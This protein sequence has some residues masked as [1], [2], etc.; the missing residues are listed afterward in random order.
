MKKL[1]RIFGLTI[2]WAVGGVLG[3]VLLVVL[4]FLVAKPT[5]TLRFFGQFAGERPGHMQ[6]VAGTPEKP[7]P[8]ASVGEAALSIESLQAAMDYGACMMLMGVTRGVATETVKR[9][10]REAQSAAAVRWPGTKPKKRS[11]SPTPKKKARANR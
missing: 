10:A 5:E 11:D 2:A 3:L 1:L 4:G 8:K 6:L 7:L 9:R